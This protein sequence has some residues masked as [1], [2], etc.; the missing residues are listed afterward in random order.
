MQCGITEGAKSVLTSSAIEESELSVIGSKDAAAHFLQLVK[1][2]SVISF[3]VLQQN[4]PIWTKEQ[5]HKIA[6]L[7]KESVSV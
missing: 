2:Y 4:H 3:G 7:H 1:V 6:I 5:A